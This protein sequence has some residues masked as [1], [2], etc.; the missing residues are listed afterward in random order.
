MR[1][2][3]TLVT[4]F[5]MLA[6]CAVSRPSTFAG[7]PALPSMEEVHRHIKAN[8]NDWDSGFAKAVGRPE[9]SVSLVSLG[10]V[11]CK[12]KHDLPACT[13]EVTGE[14]AS[15]AV[16][17]HTMEQQFDWDESGNLV[18]VTEARASG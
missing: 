4:M 8:W 7:R 5:A 11:S 18:P 17:T 1:R 14:L 9:E 13:F 6:S 16:I 3:P 15:G 10:A 12:Y 2:I